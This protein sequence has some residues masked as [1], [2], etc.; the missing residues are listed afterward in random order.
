[1]RNL[2]YGNH[3]ISAS[4]DRVDE[5]MP[6]CSRTSNSATADRDA[7]ALHRFPTL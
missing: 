6:D 1:M 7:F 2:R 4:L 5:V 3:W